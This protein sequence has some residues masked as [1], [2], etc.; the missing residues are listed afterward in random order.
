MPI[1]SIEKTGGNDY[2][3]IKATV[4]KV[5]E[6]IGGLEDVI[7][8]GYKVIIKPNLVATPAERLSGGVTRWEVCLAICEAVKAVGGIPTIA[9]SSA[10]GADT[11]A[12]IQKCGYQDLRDQG[13]PVID[14][15][16]LK[17]VC[18]IPV[19]DGEIT[20]HI[21]TWEIIRDADAIIT[22]P[23]MK[24]HDQT[25]I[26]LGMKNLKGTMTDVYKKQFHKMGLVGS[27]CDL[28]ETLKPA[29]EIIDGTFG[30]QGLG[31][32]FGE[33]KEMNLIIGSKDLVA[34]ET[35]TG[36]IMGYE[37][38]EVMITKNAA[39]RGLGEMDINKI[40]V[41]GAQIAD[42]KSRFKRS[43]EV[44]I[45]GLPTSFNLIFDSNAC[46]GCRNTV[47]SSL[48]DMKAQNLFPYLEN[49]NAI[50]GPCTKEQLPEGATAENT[51][52]IGV[53]TKKLADACGFRWVIG[54][55]PGNA[56]TVQGLL[57]DRLEYGVRYK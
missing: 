50:V 39:R 17:A 41:L 29:I 42:V 38:E 46:T 23:V 7:K 1:V 6:Q 52:C 28:V 15:K 37:P 53:C 18:N 13:I 14:L 44:E 55:P 8:P 49:M 43:C 35:V 54:C 31:P 3:S 10:A 32:I 40:T 5:I 11:E 25:E 2:A 30:Q 22:V 19:K 48:M 26:T 16:S 45:E 51:V 34:C 21:N 57:G 56:D 12:V 33:T 27:V 20:D 36:L 47:I 24:T 4:D 9:E